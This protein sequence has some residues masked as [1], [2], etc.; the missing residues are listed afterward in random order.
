MTY[1]LSSYLSST[2]H[3]LFSTLRLQSPQAAILAADADLASASPR[4]RSSLEH[5]LL[6]KFRLSQ[7][8]VIDCPFLK[9][10]LSNVLVM[11]YLDE[12]VDHPMSSTEE[13]M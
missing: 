2:L 3:L 1:M 10:V 5:V 12:L 11:R 7:W 9:T 6:A 8:V 4:A 13:S